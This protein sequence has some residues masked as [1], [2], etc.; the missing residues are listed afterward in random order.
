MSFVVQTCW[1]GSDMAMKAK[2]AGWYSE[3]VHLF[4]VFRRDL[5]TTFVLRRWGMYFFKV[6][7]SLAVVSTHEWGSVCE[8]PE[9]FNPREMGSRAVEVPVVSSTFDSSSLCGP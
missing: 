2:C 9:Y 5:S 4:G 8:L 3:C 1:W 7:E 6:G